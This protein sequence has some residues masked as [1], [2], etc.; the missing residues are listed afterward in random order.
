MKME[1]NRM[2]V[3]E[4]TDRRGAMDQKVKS[5]SAAKPPSIWLR[6]GY[7]ACIVIAMAVVVRRVLALAYP[8]RSAPPPVA[9]LDVVFASHTALTLAHIL[10]ALAFVLLTPF[11]VF[12]RT[13]E[14]A[15]AERL[16]FPL[17][18]VVGLTAYAMT[19]VASIG[20]WTE[21]SAILFFN[22]L[23]LFSLFRAWRYWQR[24]ESALKRRWML[25]AIVVLLGIATTR[26]VVG[27]FFAT[28][29]LTH[30]MPNQFF[31]VAFW[32]GFSIN[33]VAIELWLRSRDR[34]RSNAD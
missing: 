16:L 9:G 33:T 18:A 34:S 10:P 28:S 1:W 5:R 8:P 15:W 20:G 22:T 25:R 21:R 26:P 14:T 13:E 24:G 7:W 19:S 12:R 2:N 27:L 29:P 11:F 4:R 32:I 31:G 30:L 6:I 3:Q 17:G 23:F